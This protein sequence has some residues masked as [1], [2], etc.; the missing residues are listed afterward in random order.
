MKIRISIVFRCDEY[1]LIAMGSIICGT[2]L[3]VTMGDCVGFSIVFDFFDFDRLA[4][5]RPLPLRRLLDRDLPRPF[6]L[7]LLFY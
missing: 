6:R 4:R 1:E 7:D 5:R 3:I 2:R